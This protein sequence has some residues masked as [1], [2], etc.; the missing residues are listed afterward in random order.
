MG[1]NREVAMGNNRT[2]IAELKGRAGGPSGRPMRSS[3]SR[4]EGKD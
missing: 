2:F 1:V 3:K 4:C